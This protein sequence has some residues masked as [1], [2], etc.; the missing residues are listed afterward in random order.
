MGLNE[1]ALPP[2]PVATTLAAAAPRKLQAP[3]RQPNRQQPA[4]STA[5]AAAGP[6]GS[7]ALSRRSSG[8]GTAAA[9]A[10]SVLPAL[11]DRPPPHH[12]HSNGRT[13]SLTP[14]E[15][16]AFYQKFRWVNCT[17]GFTNGFGVLQYAAPHCGSLLGRMLQSIRVLSSSDSQGGCCG[18]SEHSTQV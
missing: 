6:S 8:G 2:A 17:T 16:Q 4:S 15:K 7:S 13:M 5:A 18:P 12:S 1:L 3:N 11:Q 9:A 14:A 10:G